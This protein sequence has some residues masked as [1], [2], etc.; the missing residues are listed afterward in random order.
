MNFEKFEMEIEQRLGL[1]CALLRDLE[2]EI[3]KLDPKREDI[4]A[5]LIRANHTRLK[6]KAFFSEYP[7]PQLLEQIELLDSM[8]IRLQNI[9][10]K[11]GKE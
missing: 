10:N 6:M 8:I 9:H 7:F 2:A 3:D 11:Q 4:P 5:I 1:S